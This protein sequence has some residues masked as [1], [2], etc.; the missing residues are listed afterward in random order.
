MGGKVPKV[1]VEVAPV[2]REVIEAGWQ[3][4]PAARPTMQEICVKLGKVGWSVFPGADEVK[5]AEAELALPLDETVSPATMKLKVE[6]VEK[7]NASLKSENAR[8]NG[9][10]A[11]LNGEVARLTGRAAAA[12][13]FEAE[14][15]RLKGENARLTA[16]ISRLNVAGVAVPVAPAVGVAPAP[17]GQGAVAPGTL[18]ASKSQEIASF[19]VSWRGAE[20]LF[21]CDGGKWA[22]GA[23][24]AKVAGKAPTLVLVNSPLG[25][26]GGY[27]NVPRPASAGWVADPSGTSFVFSLKPKVDRF[28]SLDSD[29]AIRT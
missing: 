24:T 3:K 15:T 16:E 14:V 13:G 21:A 18:F 27:T 19:G 1:P 9:E 25:L 5:L 10:V 22:E 20:L 8:L 28:A 12:D 4:D 6:R 29:H 11:R 26:C 7:Q 17:V 23:V 2:L